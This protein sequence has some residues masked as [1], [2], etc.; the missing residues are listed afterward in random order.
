[1]TK[2]RKTLKKI[3]IAEI[4]RLVEEKKK[5]RKE[6]MEKAKKGDEKAKKE[7]W[8]VYRLI[9]LTPQE[10]Y[11][12]KREEEIQEQIRKRGFPFEL[13]KTLSFKVREKLALYDWKEVKNDFSNLESK[14]FS[15]IWKLKMVEK[16]SKKVVEKIIDYFLEEEKNL[17]EKIIRLIVE[18]HPWKRSEE[19][20]EFWKRRERKFWK[21]KFENEKLK[22]DELKAMYK[23]MFW[24]ANSYRGFSQITLEI[25]RMEE[26]DLRKLIYKN[27]F[28][29]M[30]VKGKFKK[31]KAKFPKIEAKKAKIVKK[32]YTELYIGK[33]KGKEVVAL[34]KKDIDSLKVIIEP[35]LY[36]PF[37][38]WIFKIGAEYLYVVV[39]KRW[40]RVKQITLRKVIKNYKKKRFPIIHFGFLR[41]K[42]I[43]KTRYLYLTR[44]GEKKLKILVPSEIRGMEAEVIIKPRYRRKG[45]RI[46]VA[47]VSDQKKSFSVNI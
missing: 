47:P 13:I 15:G 3:K 45:Y 18:I 2:K 7:L 25:L 14:C 44:I 31:K 6:L 8:K 22:K 38:G 37:Y 21:K 5:K 35:F 43:L 26:K 9:I 10:Y 27:Y 39:Y 17:I 29:S 28:T 46:I 1:M 34:L 40:Y 19:E 11:R 32:R 4:R 41:E 36:L 23:R 42:R 12:R 33:K 24:N 20:K 16:Y 30:I